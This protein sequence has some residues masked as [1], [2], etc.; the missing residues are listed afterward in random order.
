MVAAEEGEGEAA[1][2]GCFQV[3]GLPHL[4]TSSRA[5]L[6]TRPPTDRPT[7]VKKDVTNDKLRATSICI[8]SGVYF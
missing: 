6:L 1:A 2:I 8:H 5:A 3:S 7:C 4:K